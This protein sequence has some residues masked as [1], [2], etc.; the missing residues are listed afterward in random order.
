MKKVIFLLV[1]ICSL[2]VLLDAQTPLDSTAI[3]QVDSLL[4]VSRNHTNKRDFVNALQ[5][6]EAAEK[7]ALEKLGRESA[8]FGSCC[9]NY[10]RVFFIQGDYTT[11][12][13]WYIDATEI[14]GRVLGKLHP[15]YAQSLTNLAILYMNKGNH[16]QAEPLLLQSMNIHEY[17]FG[18]EH[19]E[20]AKCLYNLAILKW[21]MGDLENAL[22]LN[23]EAKVI[24]ERTL[25]KEHPYYAATLMLSA[26]LYF[27]MGDYP[28]AEMI[29]L[30][31]ID[32]KEK[33]TGREHA[34][35]AASL[36]NLATLYREMGNYDKAELL[37][38]EA[39]AIQEKVLGKEH[40]EYAK[41]LNNLSTLYRE[42]GSYDKAMSLALEAKVVKEKIFGSNSS[43]Y[44]ISLSSLSALY[45]IMNDY[46]K[47]ES[48]NIEI[49]GIIEK[50]YG[51][52]HAKFAL[53]LR[54]L[55]DLYRQM[56]QF[57]KAE[58][59]LLETKTIYEQIFKKDNVLYARSLFSLALLY[60][61]RQDYSRAIPLLL[62]AKD[63]FEKEIGK[64]NH[65]YI[66]TLEHLS[67]IYGNAGNI[68]SAVELYK[69][70][71]NLNKNVVSKALH[72]LS[73]R[74]M[75]NYL[76]TLSE[77]Q[78]MLLSFINKLSDKENPIL[79]TCYDNSLFYKGLL[80]YAGGQLK[81]LALS[82][83]VTTEKFNRLKSY[84]FRL[85]AQYALPIAERDSNAVFELE[86]RANELEKELTRIVAGFNEVTQ[87]VQWRDVQA[88]LPPGA[89]AIEFVHYPFFDKNPTDSILYAALVLP[90]GDAQPQFIPL[91]EEKQL[92]SLLKTDGARK[93]DYV[94]DLYSI[95][96][97]NLKPI[98][99][100]QKSLYEL[101]WLPLE[102]VLNSTSSA[103]SAETKTVYF[104]P[105]GLLHCLN[106]GAIPITEEQT[107]ADRY[108]LVEL[109][110]TRQI[111]IPTGRAIANQNVAG[112]E[113]HA[114][115]FGGVQYEMDTT[116]IVSANVDYSSNGIVSRGGLT[117]RFA[118]STNRGGTWNYLKWTEKE[119]SKLEEILKSAGIRSTAYRGYH[120]TEE[121]FKSMGKGTGASKSPR[122]LHIATH[123]F[124]FPDLKAKTRTVQGGD[125]PIF[126]ISE[127]PMIRSGLILAGGNYAW[128]MGKPLKPGMDDGILT[129]YE[130][131]QMDLTGT[132]LAVL[133]ACET[134]LGDIAGNEGVYGLQRAFKIA[135]VKYLIMS[136]WQVPD[137][138]TQELMTT[139]YE[140][141]L[142]QKLP[143][144]QAFRSAQQAMREKYQNPYFWAGF[145]LL[146]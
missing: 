28:K 85:A 141:W 6:T 129:A 92:D 12:E 55:G 83:S 107:L 117:F 19:A 63:I 103:Q 17:I 16:E 69:E 37:H 27:D 121:A 81:R 128:Q 53:E 131:S 102:K 113:G 20:Y 8:A 26:V 87:Q 51:R 65:D 127:H 7:I 21:K 5:A 94:N 105:S 34:E 50:T 73:E 42:I 91:F 3:R 30:E 98:G 10:G 23:S 115:L 4:L 78:A 29:H 68:V 104:S 31:A 48:L 24:R 118:D 134:G 14:R 13:K 111:L 38:L 126:K 74:E 140:N 58:P 89:V 97:R 125:E 22:T 49:V 33:V 44:A 54:N 41:S 32:I 75:S 88:A 101:L 9:Y 43:E 25:G 112:D 99:K 106:L 66:G 46:E 11:A 130:I 60:E 57:E 59:L 109:G 67:V 120:A 146:E 18:K 135:G 139:F 79:Q 123:G 77:S 84:G 114:L 137:F 110:S 40:Y 80:L 1:F 36:N 45:R 96:G 76:H 86:A 136:L 2:P 143:I 133:S 100:P 124:F 72:H 119:V 82:D 35:F 15:D 64:E 132:E 116:A 47:A 52:E 39:K 144:P 122:I 142:E 145:I 93:A 90:S 70:L 108:H 56:N 61:G 138:Q 95:A 62:E 71:A